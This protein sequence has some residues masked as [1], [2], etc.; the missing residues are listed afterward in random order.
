MHRLIRRNVPLLSYVLADLR[1]LAERPRLASFYARA[2]NACRSTANAVAKTPYLQSMHDGTLEPLSYGCLTVQ[3]AYYCYHA[4]DTLKTLMGRVDH[5]GHPDLYDLIKAKAEAYDDYNRTFLEDWRIRD[6]ESVIPTETMR[7]YVQHERR[8]SREEDP[9][10]TVVA[11]LP[12]YHLWPWFARQLMMSPRYRPGV[13]QSWFEGIYQGESES[14][15]GAWVMGN[16]IEEWRDTGHPFD[17]N[18]ALDIY[19]TS[20]EFELALFSEAYA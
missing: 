8:V 20:M 3:D 17:E 12:C 19:R 11:Y 18:L 13:Y 9:I 15:G 14:F 5:E 6:T 7:R 4:Q 16:F 10:Y 1:G 2:F